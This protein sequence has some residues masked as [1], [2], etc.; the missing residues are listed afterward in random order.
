MSATIY[1][2]VSAVL[3]IAL[4]GI[5]LMIAVAVFDLVVVIIAIVKSNQ[6]KRYRYPL[7]LRLIQ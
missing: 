3:I 2:A 1:F 5:P 4:V 6:G 7:C